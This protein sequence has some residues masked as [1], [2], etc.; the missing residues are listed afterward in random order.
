MLHKTRGIVI[1]FI[2][3]RESSIIAKIYTEKFGIQTYIENGVRSSKGKNKIALFQ[4]LTL[5]DLVVYHDDKKEIHRISELKCNLPFRSVPFE[6]KKSSIAIF[7]NEI[8]NKSLKEH[9]ENETLFSFLMDAILYLDSHEDYI[10]NFH[11]YFLLNYC[12]YLGFSPASGKE[13]FEQ[14]N[15]YSYHIPHDEDTISLIDQIIHKDFGYPLKINKP[16][17]NQIL[18]VVLAFYRLHVE[19]FGEVRSLAVL[20][21][22]LA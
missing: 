6:I 22:V 12:F 8:L 21:E 1:N 15:A 4:P 10:E 17:R 11:L 18:E 13:I 20:K 3:Y 9:S 14:F 7:L 5:L 19:D 16:Q 2:K